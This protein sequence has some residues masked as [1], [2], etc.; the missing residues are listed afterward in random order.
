MIVERVLGDERVVVV[1]HRGE[2]V[3]V[4]P[5]ADAVF[6]GLLSGVTRVPAKGVLV[7]GASDASGPYAVQAVTS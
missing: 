1:V 3:T 2:G 6:D 4:D 5:G 7:L